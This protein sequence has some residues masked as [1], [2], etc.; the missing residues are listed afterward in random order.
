MTDRTV[1]DWLADLKVTLIAETDPGKLERLAAALIGKMVGVQI[2]VARSGFQFG[3]DAGAS[4]RQGRRLRLEAKRYLEST[5][6]NDR[7]LLGE[8]DQALAVDPAL[9]AWLLV[10]TRSVVEQTE[11]QLSRKGEEIGVPVIFLDWKDDA[12]IPMLAALCA[13]DP[14]IVGEL[15]SPAA[16]AASRALEAAAVP[17]IA[18]LRRDIEAW[19]LGFAGLR[20][21]A[22]AALNDI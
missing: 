8:L 11:L 18:A 19:N 21:A 3:G 17:A 15:F 5:R 12:P 9:E 13:F 22:S 20:S 1:E 10:T 7:E 14:G 4:G 6:H 16:E 2:T